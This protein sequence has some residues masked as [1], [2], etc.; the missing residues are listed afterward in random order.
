MRTRRLKTFIWVQAQQRYCER[1]NLPIY[2]LK[3]GELNVGAVILKI[4][5][6]DGRCRVFTQI[7]SVDGKTAWQSWSPDNKPVLE[8]KA[9]KYI[10]KQMA[11]DPDIWVIEIEDSGGHFKLDSIV[12]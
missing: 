12:I 3:K 7:S 5:I 11:T 2:I 10:A 4:S 9:D 8:S 1:N 6:L